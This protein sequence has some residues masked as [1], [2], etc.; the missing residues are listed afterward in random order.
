MESLLNFAAEWFSLGEV[1]ALQG[2]SVLSVRVDEWQYKALVVTVRP[3]AHDVHDFAK[4][5]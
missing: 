3:F 1:K 4:H 5:A 2:V